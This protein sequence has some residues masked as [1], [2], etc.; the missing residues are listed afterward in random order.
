MERHGIKLGIFNIDEGKWVSD[1]IINLEKE[2]C[3]ERGYLY[4][5][6]QCFNI[7]KNYTERII[8][9]SKRERKNNNEWELIMV[10]YA[11]VFD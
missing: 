7:H 2:E 3:E 4:A 5:F 11:I 8:A 9:E 1:H 10:F 6:G